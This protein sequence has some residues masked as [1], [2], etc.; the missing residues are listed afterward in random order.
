MKNLTKQDLLAAREIRYR[1]RMNL[2]ITS[3]E[4]AVKFVDDVGFCFL[5]PIQNV[6][7]PSLWDAIAGRVVRTSGKH[8]G[9]EI[10]RTWGWKDGSL[11]KKW[12]YYGKLLRDKATLVSLSLLPAFYA[13][14]F[15]GAR[16]K[17][18]TKVLH[19]AAEGLLMSAKLAASLGGGT[20]RIGP[21]RYT[22]RN[23]LRLRCLP[24]RR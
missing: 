22:M 5:F 7:M 13:L 2:R 23:A 17:W 19:L 15:F 4:Q 16:G 12:W 9:Y 20:V 1:R 18:L 11:D 24:R 3:P 8:S 6:E 10:E 21:G 14:Y